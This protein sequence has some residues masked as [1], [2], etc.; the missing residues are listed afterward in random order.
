MLKLKPGRRLSAAA[1]EEHRALQAEL[2][3]ELLGVGQLHLGDHHLDHHL[4]RLGVDPLD[5]AASISAKYCGVALT[6][7]V[8]D[9]GS[10]M[11]DHVP[12]ELLERGVEVAPAGGRTCRTS[13]RLRNVS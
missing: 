3:A 8:F 6:S 1:V 7:R 10:A 5:D 9:T 2:D 12:L 11:I 4:R 13:P